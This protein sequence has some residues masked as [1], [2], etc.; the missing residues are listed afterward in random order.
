MAGAGQP[1][2]HRLSAVRTLMQAPPCAPAHTGPPPW[3]SFPRGALT[4]SLPE[5]LQR[6]VLNPGLHPG[7]QQGTAGAK[8]WRSGQ[9][10]VG[11]WHS[12]QDKAPWRQA[13]GNGREPPSQRMVATRTGT[14]TQTEGN[15]SDWHPWGTARWPKENTPGQAR[16]SD[17]PHSITSLAGGSAK[18][19]GL[20]TCDW[21]V[22]GLLASGAVERKPPTQI[23]SASPGQAHG[24]GCP[25]L[26]ASPA[27]ALPPSRPSPDSK[28]K[29][30]Q[31]ACCPQPSKAPQHP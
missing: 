31:A 15:G 17:S 10:W 30:E 26:H 19:L 22:S 11:W 5:L 7:L 14:G 29:S 1:P 20:V 25:D 9:W 24:N 13:G 27:P 21:Q 16:H 8:G 2:S 6:S 18:C 12:P 3:A 23:L 28:C 4:G